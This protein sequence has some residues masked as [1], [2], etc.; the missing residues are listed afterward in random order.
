[1]DLT[2]DQCAVQPLS[3]ARI[4]LEI[5]AYDCL[6]GLSCSERIDSQSESAAAHDSSFLQLAV[7]AAFRQLI[8][9]EA[10]RN[11][12]L[13]R[14]HCTSRPRHRPMETR[15]N[16]RGASTVDASSEVSSSESYF[17]EKF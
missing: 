5:R 2:A 6:V 11:I 15:I 4:C 17:L 13:Y 10:Q 7:S 8:A 14:L 1:M 9:L 16:P 3:K 12:E